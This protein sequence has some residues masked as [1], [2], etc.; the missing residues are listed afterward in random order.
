MTA[1]PAS[2]TRGEYPGLLGC[3]ALIAGLIAIVSGV[4]LA[5][6]RFWWGVSI[7]VA[8]VVAIGLILSYAS[9]VERDRWRRRFDRLASIA[10]PE[11]EAW[12]DLCEGTGLGDFVPVIEDRV[13]Q[14]VRVESHRAESEAIGIGQSRIGGLHDLPR[15]F[16][17]PQYKG[18]SLRFL[19]QF[20]LAEVHKVHP[21]ETLPAEGWLW[22]FYEPGGTMD[23]SDPADAGSARTY[24]AAEAPLE[25]RALPDDLVSGYAYQF[26]RVSFAQYDDPPDIDFDTAL[27]ESLTDE[28]YDAYC[29]I[30]SYLSGESTGAEHKLLGN[31]QPVQGP[32]ESECEQV[33]NGMSCAASRGTE[34]PGSLEP[35]SGAT[36]WRLL[37]QLECG[38]EAGMFWGDLGRVYFWIR[39][40]DLRERRFERIWAIA[41]CT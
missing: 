14:A 36:Q 20:D 34:E 37:L 26:C 17:W 40:S 3:S 25:R 38:D 35:A 15:G 19:A 10:P 21:E 30:R 13:R 28:Q 41:Q 2:D 31:P 1:S 18:R 23:G 29:D 11:G 16:E 24:F 8:S 27:T 22:F 4:V 33:A 7:S 9:R 6:F 12:R 32:M 39:A 5:F